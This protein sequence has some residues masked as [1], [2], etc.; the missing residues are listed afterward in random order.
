MAKKI[1][2]KEFKKL[3]KK[4]KYLR[5]QNDMLSFN[6][7]MARI[8][9]NSVYGATANPNLP[10]SILNASLDAS[11]PKPSVPSIWPEMFLHG[12]TDDCETV[13][14]VMRLKDYTGY[15]VQKGIRIVPAE[16]N[17]CTMELI[18]YDG[19]KFEESCTVDV[20]DSLVVI[21][22]RAIHAIFNEYVDNSYF[23]LCGERALQIRKLKIF[24]KLFEHADFINS[25]ITADDII[26]TSDECATRAV[27]LIA[28]PTEESEE[29]YKRDMDPTR[30]YLYDFQVI[31]TKPLDIL[32]DDTDEPDEDI[33]NGCSDEEDIE[34]FINDDL[35]PDSNED[36]CHENVNENNIDNC[37][38]ENISIPEGGNKND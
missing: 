11:Q 19:A 17:K 2:K 26:D 34:E 10:K 31:K 33:D 22:E 7:N 24:S 3:R 32:L 18:G 25:P 4:V 37:G 15:M 5:K 12:A 9:L 13:S 30:Y 28:P 27:C 23:T 1:S 20:D 29:N 6:N 14:F 21:I 38:D 35:G 16:K 8:N 36:G